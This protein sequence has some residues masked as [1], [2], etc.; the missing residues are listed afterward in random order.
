MPVLG[1]RL[2]ADA[3]A[4]IQLR[5]LARPRQHGTGAGNQRGLFT[6]LRQDLPREISE[7][8]FAHANQA[9]IAWQRSRRVH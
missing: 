4:N 1:W 6:A 3:L 5:C 2:V 9:V 8:M 7:P